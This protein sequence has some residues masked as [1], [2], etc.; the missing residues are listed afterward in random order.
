MK[1]HSL[2]DLKLH[3]KIQPRKLQICFGGQIAS[4]SRRSMVPMPVFSVC[5][6]LW[7]QAQQGLISV[8][9]AEREALSL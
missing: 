2:T 6:P 3:L 4:A 5:V 9:A 8:Q 7:Q 1:K